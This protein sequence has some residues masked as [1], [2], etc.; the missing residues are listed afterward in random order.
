MPD[1]QDRPDLIVLRLLCQHGFGT[2]RSV[3]SGRGRPHSERN[4]RPGVRPRHLPSASLAS[5]EM[6]SAELSIVR[7][8]YGVGDVT[9]LTSGEVAAMLGTQE[10]GLLKDLA[11]AVGKLRQLAASNAAAK[12]MM[13]R[14]KIPTAGEVA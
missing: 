10:T 13:W 6:P 14:Y 1:D 5:H 8:R 9:S 4:Q 3:P 11:A 12:S 2:E 7:L